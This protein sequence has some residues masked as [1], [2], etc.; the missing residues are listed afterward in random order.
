MPY[1]YIYIPVFLQEPFSINNCAAK[2]KIIFF[3]SLYA[4]L[5]CCNVYL[6]VC[7]LIKIH[8]ELLYGNKKAPAHYSRCF[9]LCFFNYS[10]QIIFFHDNNNA[11]IEKEETQTT[12]T[13]IILIRT[14]TVN[15]LCYL[16]S[17]LRSYL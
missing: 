12:N 6:F 4:I 7:D 9:K 5:I 15:L 13:Y 1:F 3:R 16:P 14:N 2:H 10:P 11:T 17:M 8:T